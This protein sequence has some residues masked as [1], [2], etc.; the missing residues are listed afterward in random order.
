MVNRPERGVIA[1]VVLLVTVSMLTSCGQGST[2]ATA[3]A[4]MRVSASSPFDTAVAVDG[5]GLTL[6]RFDGDRT[7]PPTSTCLDACAEQ[8]PPLLVTGDVIVEG[9]AGELVGTLRR[10]DGTEQVTLG[11]WPLYTHAGD[12]RAGDFLGQASAGAW[13]AIAPNGEKATGI[14]RSQ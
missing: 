3:P 1:C 11:G 2:D 14:S 6:Y 7:D 4:T 10:P 5:D 8:W 12:Q 13:Y 9:M